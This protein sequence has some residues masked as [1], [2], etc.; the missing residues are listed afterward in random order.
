MSRSFIVVRHKKLTQ[1]EISKYT[2]KKQKKKQRKYK[3][4][5]K[6]RMEKENYI[7]QEK[8][9]KSILPDEHIPSELIE[10][11]FKIKE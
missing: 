10:Q 11:Q 2:D 6:L 7:T 9:E 1:A 5:K 8:E 4:E 3:S